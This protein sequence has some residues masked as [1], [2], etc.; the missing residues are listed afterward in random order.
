MDLLSRVGIESWD[1]V[2]RF[3]AIIMKGFLDTEQ[4]SIENSI[5]KKKQ[6]RPPFKISVIHSELIVLIIQHIFFKDYKVTGR[7]LSTVTLVSELLWL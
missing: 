2:F 6:N 7:F 3:A 4:T 5:E 1:K